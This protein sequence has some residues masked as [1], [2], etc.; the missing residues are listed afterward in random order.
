MK[1]LTL[2]AVKL[3]FQK[4]DFK[5]YVFLS[6]YFGHFSVV[7][8]LL[9]R[10]C[11]TLVLFL[12]KLTLQRKNHFASHSKPHLLMQPFKHAWN[13]NIYPYLFE[14]VFKNNKPNTAFKNSVN[15]HCLTLT[16]TWH[17]YKKRI[18]LNFLWQDKGKIFSALPGQYQVVYLWG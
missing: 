15:K 5:V 10:I 16:L 4:F 17:L 6:L 12:W 8:L 9:W 1:Y 13:I 2:F 14:Q 18:C 11:K 3:S 7:N